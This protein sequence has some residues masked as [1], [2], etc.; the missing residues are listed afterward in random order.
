MRIFLDN[1]GYVSRWTEKDDAGYM[2]ENDIVVAAPAGLDF[3]VFRNEYK[4]YKLVD[5][6]LVK[7]ESRELP[8]V[9][10]PAQ[11]QPTQ[12][13]RIEAQVTYTAMMTDTLL[14]V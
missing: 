11:D 3:S 2:S 10:F 13:D 7:D 12:I 8:Q 1:D 14:E 9:E 4:Y 6:V 5:G